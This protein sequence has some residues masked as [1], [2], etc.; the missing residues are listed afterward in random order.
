ML[1]LLARDERLDPPLTGVLASIPIVLSP[2]AVPDAVKAEYQSRH[3][4]GDAP[5]FNAKLINYVTGQFFAIP[6]VGGDEKVMLTS[7]YNQIYMLRMST[8]VSS[9]LSTGPPGTKGFPLRSFRF[10]VKHQTLCF[11]FFSVR[12]MLTIFRHGSAPG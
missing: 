6:M 11:E 12:E 1:A 3:Q 9:T 5:G 2:E 7:W 10:A 8:P 4:N